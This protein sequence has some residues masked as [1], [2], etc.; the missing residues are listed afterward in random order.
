MRPPTYR[1]IK[2]AFSPGD[3]IFVLSDDEQFEPVRIR[4]IERKAF[5]TDIG[6]ILFED[7]GWLWRCTKPDE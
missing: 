2:S 5:V 3:E 1:M 6:K 7:H 4:S